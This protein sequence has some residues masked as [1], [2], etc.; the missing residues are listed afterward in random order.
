MNFVKLFELGLVGTF[1]VIAG[2]LILTN[3]K[4]D[5]V[6]LTGGQNAYV[7]GVRALEGR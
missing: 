4:S 7:G 3:P 5:Q 6:L 1:A 2:Y